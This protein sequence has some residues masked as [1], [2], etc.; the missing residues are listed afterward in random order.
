MIAAACAAPYKDAAEMAA[1]ALLL[2]A[3]AL[4]LW[5]VDR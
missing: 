2:A 4:L 3:V 5:A 1:A